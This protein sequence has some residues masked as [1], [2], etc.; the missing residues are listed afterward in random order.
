M[1]R[2]GSQRLLQG[3]VER[4]PE[5]LLR[6]LRKG[7]A[8]GSRETVEWMSP[9][10]LDGYKEYRDGAALAQLRVPPLRTPL[11]SFWPPRGPVWDALGVTSDGRRILVE[12]K[13]HIP[14][15]ASGETKA[16]DASR[17]VIE[18]ALAETRRHLAPR[19]K[20]DW[21]RPFYQYA[22]R[23]AFQY[24]LRELNGIPSALVFL[25][26]INATEMDGPTSE[27]QWHG[28]IRLIHA[29]LGLPKDLSE[30]GVHE[31]F[32]DARKLMAAPRR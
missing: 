5:A 11:R 14:E 18:R 12:A 28:A 31:A 23:L 13:A 30:F 2:T 10:E 8:V 6:A 32:V 3:A 21:T 24:F 19:S 27:K 9:R 1:P 17:K 16:S 22:N 4:H 25:Y 20:A 26:F 7:G 15:A 29:V